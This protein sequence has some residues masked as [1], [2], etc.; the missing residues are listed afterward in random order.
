MYLD[1][2]ALAEGLRDLFHHGED[3]Q[4]ALTQQREIVAQQ[5]SIVEE[6]LERVLDLYI[7]KQFDEVMLTK[8]RA[9]LKQARTVLT[10][11]VTE[12]DAR[13]AQLIPA[14]EEITNLQTFAAEV[15]QSLEVL[16]FAAKRR[17]IDMLDVRATI[18]VNEDGDQYVDVTS[19][20]PNTAVRLPLFVP[21][22]ICSWSILVAPSG[23]AHAAFAY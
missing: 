21:R 19:S 23:R 15:Q 16:G 6:K 22:P 9:E 4:A 17:V 1:P 14:E 7:P 20:L 5:L 13:L 11:K 8:R 2:H 3:E 12:T 18:G 10:W